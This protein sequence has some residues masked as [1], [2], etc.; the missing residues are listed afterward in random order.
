MMH[1]PIGAKATV[2]VEASEETL[3][4][5]TESPGVGDAPR[6]TLGCVD[7]LVVPFVGYVGRPD[8]KYFP[9][10][11]DE[12]LQILQAGLGRDVRVDICTADEDYQELDLH[13]DEL[14]VAK[15]IFDYVLWPVVVSTIS[16]WIDR[17]RARRHK[18]L[19]VRSKFVLTK[20]PAGASLEVSYDGPAT[21]Y[22]DVMQKALAAVADNSLEQGPS[23][24]R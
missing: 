18:D 9:E 3:A 17:L 7:V 16:S 4:S 24:K 21:G 20:T 15:M 10:G 5:W 11:T 12:L 13:S 1:D 22:R 8:L 19:R 14:R 6:T 23:G 2:R